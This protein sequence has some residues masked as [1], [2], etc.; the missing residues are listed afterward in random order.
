[1]YVLIHH[2]IK[3]SEAFWEINEKEEEGESP[4]VGVSPFPVFYPYAGGRML[5]VCI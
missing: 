2:K 3:D 1:M 5:F 4:P